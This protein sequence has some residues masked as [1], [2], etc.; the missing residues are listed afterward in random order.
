[1]NNAI[2][3]ADFY[4]IIVMLKPQGF[5]MPTACVKS[6]QRGDRIVLSEAFERMCD[7]CPKRLLRDIQDHYDYGEITKFFYAL[8]SIAE[9]FSITGWKLAEAFI[10]AMDSGLRNAKELDRVAIRTFCNSNK[11]MSVR[12][13]A[14]R[15]VFYRN[16]VWGPERIYEAPLVLL[17]D[18][19]GLSIVT[20]GHAV[21]VEVMENELCH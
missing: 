16:H 10:D 19:H 6:A 20:L 13:S 8:D 1:M 14:F 7:I 5:E 3:H 2:L 12:I 11:S 4:G 9:E 17:D 15:T 21:D 18:D